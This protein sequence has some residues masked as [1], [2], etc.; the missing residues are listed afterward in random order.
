MVDDWI[1][2]FLESVEFDDIGLEE[3]EDGEEVLELLTL[4]MRM[5]EN[6]DM[7][8][9]TY[10]L[11]EFFCLEYVGSGY[12][13]EIVCANTCPV[14][15]AFLRFLYSRNALT[16]GNELALQIEL[17]EP[18]LADPNRPKGDESVLDAMVALAQKHDFD[19]SDVESN[20]QFLQYCDENEEELVQELEEAFLA[21]ILAE[22][23]EWNME[24]LKVPLFEEN[25]LINFN[26]EL[27]Y[28]DTA[29][30]WI[31]ENVRRLIE[32]IEAQGR[33]KLTAKGFL[34]RKLILKMYEGLAC[35]EE[36]AEKHKHYTMPIEQDIYAVTLA[37]VG[38]E[39][40]GMIK[41]VDNTM[42]VT[43]KGRKIRKRDQA[44]AIYYRLFK[45]LFGEVDL[46]YFDGLAM[47]AGFQQLL[48]VLLWRIMD[49]A[50]TE[51]TVQ[52][53]TEYVLEP[54]QVKALGIPDR[55]DEIK[56]AFMSKRI[57]RHLEQFGLL[58]RRKEG[59]EAI[60][61]ITPL[62]T[63]FITFSR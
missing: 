50:D 54:F 38:A 14:L 24:L 3:R 45:T 31:L 41:R 56:A 4:H 46:R 2:P 59:M 18:I 52:Q 22:E 8:Q 42:E 11:L 15:S 13:D 51:V 21:R 60:V 49:Y 53:L 34:P 20:K 63:K 10:E 23:R 25:E 57:L 5:S 48:G 27:S 39:D 37:R 33:V 1:E 12:M 35:A 29:G 17:L 61:R 58:E 7:R 6:Q 30:V 9:W 40:T 55:S 62:F 26:R 43:A 16:K 19:I 36:E 44:G 32:M 28:E 47:A